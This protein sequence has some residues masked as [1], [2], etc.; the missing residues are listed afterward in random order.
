MNNPYAP[1]LSFLAAGTLGL[2]IGIGLGILL[3][4]ATFFVKKQSPIFKLSNLIGKN[5]F[6]ITLVIATASTLSSLFLSEIAHFAPCLLCWVQRIF[7][8]PL[9]VIL[10]VAYFLNDLKARVT[11]F[12]L[13]LIGFSYAVY[14][15]LVQ[16]FPASF[17]CSDEI[18]NCALKSFTYYGFI[19]IPVMS[20]TAF[21]AILL[22]LLFSA[23]TSKSPF[24]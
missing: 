17:K 7:M 13:S 10:G 19:T 18:A 24:K 8:Y 21:A 23:R 2:Q 4:F 12:V 16:F 9:V 1:F 11:A 3:F 6:L 22:V 5:A 15:I 14:H 20:A